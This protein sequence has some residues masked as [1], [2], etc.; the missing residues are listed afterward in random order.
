MNPGALKERTRQFAVRVMRLVDRPPKRPAAR[1]I[2]SQLV[3]CATSV[4]ANYHIA[5]RARSKAEFLAKLGIVLEECDESQ[6]WLQLI[7]DAELMPSKRIQSLLDGAAE[8][9]AIFTSSIKTA[10]KHPRST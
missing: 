4:G 3:R 10:Q 5:C 6:F 2:G 1:G 7:I 8:L 9:T